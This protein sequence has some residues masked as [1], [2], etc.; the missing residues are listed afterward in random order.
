MHRA[1][2]DSAMSVIPSPTIAPVRSLPS[3]GAQAGRP[4]PAT[5]ERARTGAALRDAGIDLA[6]LSSVANVTYA[7]GVEVPLAYGAGFELSYGP[8]LAV[9]PASATGGTLVAPA[10]NAGP[11]PELDMETLGFDTLTTWEAPDP[12]GTYLARLR[13]ALKSAG[14]AGGRGRLG[15]ETRSLPLAAVRAI[16]AALPGWEI[17]DAEPALRAARTIKTT[18]EIDLLRRASHLADVSHVA[19][20]EQCREAGRNE[21][22][23]YAEI[24]RAIF[25]AAGREIPLA[26]ELVFGPR[27]TTVE[28]PYNGPFDR[29][30]EPGD[31]ALMDLSGRL[32]GY[33]FD[34]TNTH[35]V[36][37]IE[38][39][40]E[41]LRY[42]RASR[43]ACEA[44]MA[45]L[46]PGARASDA[47]H[48]AESAFAAFDLPMAH[49]AGHQIGVTVNELPRLVPYD[50]TPIEAGMVFCVEP[51]AYQGPGGS[52]GARSEKTVLVTE[53]RP[54]ILSTFAW[55]I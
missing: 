25:Q 34:C 20:A 35:V 17:V 22:A 4:S 10:G 16:E 3:S 23:M 47:F 54:E 14:A 55:G 51:G 19:L 52:V 26:G 28:Y 48:A 21:I 29:V 15:V 2:P 45:A 42:A 27:T 53:A 31:T 32:D 39:T 11:A 24:C 30:V 6:V 43:A 40:K 13:E 49:Y 46:T 38:P 12:E 37:G 8:W 5:E 9:L 18:R 41:Q 50:H 36:G 1:L 7:T 33:W 44:G